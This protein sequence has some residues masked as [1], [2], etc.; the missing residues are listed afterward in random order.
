M[1]Q[2]EDVESSVKVYFSSEYG[3]FKFLPGNRDLNE[4]KIDKI[5]KV[6]KEEGIDVLKYSPVIVNE[7]YQIIDG[8]HRFTVAK[9]LK[10]P[11]FYVKIEDI[12]LSGVA[13]INSNSS[14]WKVKDYLNSYSDLKKEPYLFVQKTIAQYKITPVIL[15]HLIH[16]KGVKHDVNI[17]ELFIDGLIELN[18]QIWTEEFLKRLSKYENYIKS[19]YSRRSV[20]AFIRLENKGKFDHEHMVGKFKM[21]KQKI[22]SFSS[23][24]D[25]IMQMETIANFKAKERVMIY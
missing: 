15:S 18:H 13:K 24:K 25:L 4:T 5:V 17:K 7:K 23:A 2:I 3:R 11:I 19:P 10:R 1:K 12:G 6:I 8:Q 9:K 14:N 21:A 20:E 22:E 16:H